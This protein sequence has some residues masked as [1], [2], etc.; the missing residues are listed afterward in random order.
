MFS[1]CSF[2]KSVMV[3]PILGIVAFQSRDRENLAN[4]NY[5]TVKNQLNLRIQAN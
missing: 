1:F 3:M 5:P 4:I 2:L